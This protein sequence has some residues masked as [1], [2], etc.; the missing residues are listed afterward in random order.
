MALIDLTDSQLIDG[1]CSSQGL[2][3]YPQDHNRQRF[4]RHAILYR[5]GR[6]PASGNVYDQPKRFRTL[7]TSGYSSNLEPIGELGRFDGY[8]SDASEINNCSTSASQTNPA[9]DNYHNSRRYLNRRISDTTGWAI[10]EPTVTSSPQTFQSARFKGNSSA[11]S[12]NESSS[13]SNKSS[14]RHS[15]A[16]LS[17][18]LSLRNS[19]SAG[20]N[21]FSTQPMSPDTAFAN[22]ENSLSHSLQRADGLQPLGVRRRTSWLGSIRKR[23]KRKDRKNGG[24]AETMPITRT[25]FEENG[26]NIVGNGYAKPDM[27]FTGPLFERHESPNPGNSAGV[28]PRLRSQ[29]SLCSSTRNTEDE[30]SYTTSDVVFVPDTDNLM[31]SHPRIVS[32]VHTPHSW[33]TKRPQFMLPYRTNMSENAPYKVLRE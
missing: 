30:S 8:L 6:L 10:D 28:Y 5:E 31:S 3:G 12:G 7:D 33:T 21:T 32:L 1:A 15:W 18:R 19:A 17:R 14:S 9:L 25:F 24:D 29:P 16:T 13:E 22:R 27:H 11:S 23:I 2:H 20:R 26:D 4:S